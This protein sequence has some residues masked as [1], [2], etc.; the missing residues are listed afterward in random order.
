M[1]K[2]LTRMNPLVKE[3][4]HGLLTQAATSLIACEGDYVPMECPSRFSIHVIDAN[5]GL[6]DASPCGGNTTVTSCVTPE[7]HQ[8]I[9]EYCKGS[10]TCDIL[11][12]VTVFEDSCPDVEKY[13]NVT[14]ECQGGP[15]KETSSTTDI[16]STIPKET[17]QS[18]QTL[19]TGVSCSCTDCQK[20]V[21]NQ[22]SSVAN[23]EIILE[24]TKNIAAELK[25]DKKTL[26]SAKRRIT[27][28][29]DYRVSA[30]FMGYIG[31]GLLTVVFG[32]VVF[33]DIVNIVI[34][35]VLG[36]R[37]ILYDI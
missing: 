25:L 21:S 27:S 17:T 9:F 2:R 28:A 10:N 6:T 36:Q 5:F 37:T 13:L 34:P 24:L 19:T 16:T 31:I 15:T 11:S 8:V 22:L 23:L 12:S 33:T 26:S 35:C 3:V 4:M 20:T 7:T 14:F 29:S 30:T 32:L 18:S 1:G